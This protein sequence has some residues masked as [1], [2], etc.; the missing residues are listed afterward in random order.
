L[1]S[2][3]DIE[4]KDHKIFKVE[5]QPASLEVRLFLFLTDVLKT[6]FSIIL[7]FLEAP[8]RCRRVLDFSSSKG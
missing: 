1:L 8:L 4:I 5:K 2:K 6:I 7:L 3:V